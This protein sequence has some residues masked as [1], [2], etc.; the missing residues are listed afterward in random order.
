MHGIGC[1]FHERRMGNKC[2]IHVTGQYLHVYCILQAATSFYW[3]W[4][5]RCP[6]QVD[7]VFSIN[8]GAAPQGWQGGVCPLSISKKKKKKHE[9][10][11]KR[12]KSRKNEEKNKI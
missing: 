10:E 9:K 3:V 4:N 7:N 11:E 6:K 8:P 1:Q 5:I 2:I 12:G